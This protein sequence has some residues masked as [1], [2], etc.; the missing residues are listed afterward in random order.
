MGSFSN[1]AQE[2][3]TQYGTHLRASDQ[4]FDN[5]IFVP[6]TTSSIPLHRSSERR[7]EQMTESQRLNTQLQHV[8]S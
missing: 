3:M 4:Y 2:L 7:G 1:S 8:S 5:G 6:K